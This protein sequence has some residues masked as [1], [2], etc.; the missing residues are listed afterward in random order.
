VE[1]EPLITAIN[2]RGKPANKY[3]DAPEADVV[4]RSVVRACVCLLPTAALVIGTI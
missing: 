2:T 3:R 1:K 4:A